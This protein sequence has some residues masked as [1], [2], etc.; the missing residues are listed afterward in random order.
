MSLVASPDK[1]HAARDRPRA[2]HTDGGSP[3]VYLVALVVIALT[4]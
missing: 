1:T 2:R 4:L 3:L